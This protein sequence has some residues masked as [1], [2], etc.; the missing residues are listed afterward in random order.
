MTPSLSVTLVVQLAIAQL[1]AFVSLLLV[2]AGVHKLHD[3]ARAEQAMSRLTGIAAG[4]AAPAALLLAGLEIA[5]GAGLWV[6]P[7]RLDAALLAVLI[8]C[9]YFVFLVQAVASGQRA[10]DCGCSFA[11][12][13]A[14]LG[15]FEVLRAGALALLAMV[16][17]GSAGV[18]PG[19]VAYEVGAAALTTQ[20]LAGV[21]LFVLYVALDQV[22][23]VKPLRSGSVA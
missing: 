21:A 6:P 14:E 2:A 15:L 22:M 8:W 18:A 9:G 11:A 5:A 4:Q 23:A 17:A 7:L 16:I 1:G 3:R 13:N 20:L 10:V 19:A 12:S